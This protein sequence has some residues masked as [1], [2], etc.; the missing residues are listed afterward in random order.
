MRLRPQHAALATPAGVGSGGRT[1]RYQRRV[2]GLQDTLVQADGATQPRSTPLKTLAWPQGVFVNCR[3]SGALRPEIRRSSMQLDDTI[4]KFVMK[5][6]SRRRL[7]DRPSP[8]AAALQHQ[9]G[10]VTGSPSPSSTERKA[11]DPY[12]V[13]TI[14]P[15]MRRRGDPGGPV[16]STGGPA[17]L[18]GSAAFLSVDDGDGDLY[19]AS[20]VRR[21]AAAGDGGQEGVLIGGSPGCIDDLRISGRSA[22]LPPAVNNTPWGQA[23]V[24]KGVER[25]CVAPSA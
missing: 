17:G 7:P 1:S 6:R 13:F 20:R 4:E 18:Y 15:P 10:V 8:A 3:G 14:S 25:G 2:R 19:N 11:A 9:R 12:L 22:P 21:D 16:P 5:R 24:F 23:S